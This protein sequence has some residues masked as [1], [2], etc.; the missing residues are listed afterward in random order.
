VALSQLSR[1]AQVRLIV[2]PASCGKTTLASHIAHQSGRDTVVLQCRGPQNDGAS[3]LASLLQSA[4]LA[5]WDLSQIDQ[6]NLLTVFV[7]QRRSQGRRI[8]VLVDDAQG[9]K[10]TALEELER[11][12]ALRMDNRPALEWVVAGPASLP[13]LWLRS[14]A[15]AVV[16]LH[17][18]GPAS[19]E[20]LSHYLDWRLRRFEM[21][22]FVTPVATQMIARLSGGRYA[23][24]D[25]LCQIS[26][27][28]LRQLGLE[29]VDARVVRQ[30]VA[31]LV[32][33]QGAKLE[34]EA[35]PTDRPPD[36]PPQAS[37][38]VSRDGTVLSKVALRERTLV[39]RSE[40]NHVCLPSAYLSR[41]HAV[42]V[43]TPEGYYLV[44]LNSANGVALNGRR[45]ER[46][47]LCDQDVLTMG[48]FRLKIQIPESLARGSPLPA[49]ESLAETALMAQQALDSAIWRVK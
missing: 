11:L 38:Y 42:I 35:G 22:T 26:L 20:D 10:P 6:R 9:F 27:L 5:P 45:V 43:G 40:H 46:A 23:A 17:E 30:A 1:P 7:Q 12:L 29:R 39:G 28:V 14:L 18:L 37:L 47:V 49:A 15:E 13:R 2:G 44:D 25:I 24:A 48:P 36:A 31:T 16:I 4:G 34:L 21:E 19:I 33:R 32:A 41:H 3:V 8:L